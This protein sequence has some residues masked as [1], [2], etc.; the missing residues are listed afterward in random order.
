MCWKPYGYA[1][2]SVASDAY[3][4]N[5][6]TQR[7]APADCEQVFEEVGSRASWNRTGLNRLTA[8]SS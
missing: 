2:V 6:S 1:R 4:N 5:L 3:A 8:A 7:R